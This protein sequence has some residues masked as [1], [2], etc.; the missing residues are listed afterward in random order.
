MDSAED[1]A[2]LIGCSVAKNT[3]MMDNGDGH[4]RRRK[5][6]RK[7]YAPRGLRKIQEN[8]ALQGERVQSEDIQGEVEKYHAG[9]KDIRRQAQ[10]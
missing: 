5:D 8:K 3:C 6:N 2:T 7:S 10:V 4:E 9:G 1:G